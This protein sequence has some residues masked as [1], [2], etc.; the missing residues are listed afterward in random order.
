MKRC[1]TFLNVRELQ[2]KTM[3]YYLTLV[4]MAIIKSLQII[5]F[6]ENVEDKETSCTVGGNV[7]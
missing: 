1:S 5:N 3:R 2:I 4:R 7:N 6:G